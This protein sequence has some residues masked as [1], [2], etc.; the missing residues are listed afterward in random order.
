MLCRRDQSVPA[1]D[2]SDRRQRGSPGRR[3]A[4]ETQHRLERCRH[5]AP[6][7]EPRRL[8]PTACKDGQNWRRKKDQSQPDNRA[9]Q[10]RRCVV[11]LGIGRPRDHRSDI[12]DAPVGPQRKRPPGQQQ[13]D[14]AL[15][16]HQ[17]GQCAIVDQRGADGSDP[18]RLRQRRTID[19]HHPARRSRRPARTIDRGKGKQH[20]EK[21]DESR[22][23]RALGEA[24]G[25]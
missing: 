21:P 20:H 3:A 16:F 5:R 13:D 19:Q 18:A 11:Q 4:V 8:R 7:H 2:G 10:Q 1:I 25:A 24:V 12:A 22:H 15:R 6:G 23:Q 17:L 14:F 9:G